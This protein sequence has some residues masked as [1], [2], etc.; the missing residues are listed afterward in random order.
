MKNKKLLKAKIHYHKEVLKIWKPKT[1]A[2]IDT[3]KK[4]LSLQKRLQKR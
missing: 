1:K 3:K 2:Y 4:I